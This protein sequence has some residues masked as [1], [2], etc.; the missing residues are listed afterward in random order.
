MTSALIKLLSNRAVRTVI[1]DLCVGV[2]I[3][4]VTTLRKREKNEICKRFLLHL[5]KRTP[6]DGELGQKDKVRHEGEG[7]T[8]SEEG[9]GRHREGSYKRDYM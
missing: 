4:V 6:N 5:Q 9:K 7:N 8:F 1:I 2:T 3:G